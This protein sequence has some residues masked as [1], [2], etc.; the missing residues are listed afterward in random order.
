M[1]DNEQGKV[2]WLSF[3]NSRI[4]PEGHTL[5]SD[6]AR[7]LDDELQ[8]VDE[9]AALAKRR[10]NAYTSRLCRLPV[11]VLTAILIEVKHTWKPELIQRPLPESKDDWYELAVEYRF[12]PREQI[13]EQFDVD[14]VARLGWMNATYV[15]SIMRQVALASPSLWCEIDCHEY[16]AP[17][18]NLIESRSAGRLLKLSF[19]F[20]WGKGARW[21]DLTRRWFTPSI[22]ARLQSL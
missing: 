11:E 18:H 22:L 5:S 16:T 7:N 19:N 6:I 9:F 8:L 14:L 4:P 17:F 21:Y 12:K 10:R 1:A 13:L 2:V 3:I 20:D 15:C